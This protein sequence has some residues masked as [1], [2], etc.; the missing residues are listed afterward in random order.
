MGILGI[1]YPRR[2][3]WMSQEEYDEL[4]DDIYDAEC[5]REDE[6]LERDFD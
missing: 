2:E 4:C 1:S 3:E 6:Y 5:D